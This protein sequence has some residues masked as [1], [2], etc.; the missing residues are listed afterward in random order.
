MSLYVRC[1]CVCVSELTNIENVEKATWTKI[2]KKELL[3]TSVAVPNGP[4]TAILKEKYK[5]P[6]KNA[7]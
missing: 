4:S 1:V 6:A 3:H 7:Q 2:Y 5:Q